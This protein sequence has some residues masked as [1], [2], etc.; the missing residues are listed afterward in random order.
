MDVAG[1]E[2]RAKS[3]FTPPHKSQAFGVLRLDNMQYFPV[4]MGT[5][6]A[7]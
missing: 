7:I 1:G 3:P 5:L 2:G 6:V 4:N